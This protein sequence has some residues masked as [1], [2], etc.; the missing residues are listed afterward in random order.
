MFNYAWARLSQSLSV[1][2]FGLVVPAETTFSLQRTKMY[3]RNFSP[4]ALSYQNTTLSTY[5]SI[6]QITLFF[7]QGKQ[8][9]VELTNHFSLA[10]LKRQRKFKIR[11][12]SAIRPLAQLVFHSP[13]ARAS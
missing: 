11:D 5:T 13:I 7:L 12:K 1:P 2:I 3:G 4:V 10:P 6:K 8:V 9:K